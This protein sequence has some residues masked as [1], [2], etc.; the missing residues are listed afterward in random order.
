MWVGRR[1]AGVWDTGTVASGFHRVQGRSAVGLARGVGR[2]LE[3][4]GWCVA[5]AVALRWRGPLGAGRLTPPVRGVA[6]RDA[7]TAVVRAVGRVARRLPLRS[8]CLVRSVAGQAMLA[9]RG[10]ATELRIGVRPGAGTIEAHAW[11][12]RDGVVLNDRA[13]IGEAFA[14]FVDPID[15][16]AGARVG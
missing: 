3:A 6:R 11:L 5:V 7:T 1:G 13:D 10:V 15:L 8:P 16:G 2:H 9:R 14:A 12:E 4:L